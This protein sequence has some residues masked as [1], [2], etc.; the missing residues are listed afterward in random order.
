MKKNIFLTDFCL[1][2]LIRKH[3]DVTVFFYTKVRKIKNKLKRKPS[4]PNKSHCT[5]FFT[6][7]LITLVLAKLDP[8]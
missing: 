7:F 3:D 5:S 2:M 1:E 4:I 8:K 6:H